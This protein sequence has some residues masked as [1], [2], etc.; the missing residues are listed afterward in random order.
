MK[1]N[2]QKNSFSDRLKAQGP[3]P[4]VPFFAKNFLPDNVV[5]ADLLVLCAYGFFAVSMILLLR[6]FEDSNFSNYILLP[7]MAGIIWIVGT[8][9]YRLFGAIAARSKKGQ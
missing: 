3:T 5:I 8:F 1:N 9:Y 6:Q 2:N 7:I 4:Y